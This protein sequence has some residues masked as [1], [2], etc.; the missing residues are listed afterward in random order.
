MKLLRYEDPKTEIHYYGL[1]DSEFFKD[2]DPK[3][4]FTVKNKTL[5][6]VEHDIEHLNL[7]YDRVVS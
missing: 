5:N 1:S 7:K 4:I 3:Y 6:Q 2:K